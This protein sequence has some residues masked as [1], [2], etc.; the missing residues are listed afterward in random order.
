V[1]AAS[2]TICQASLKDLDALVP[3]FDA[4]RQF[5]EQPSDLNVARRFLTD[6]LE[7]GESIIFMAI[8]DGQAIGFTQLYPS[9][10]STRACPIYI[11]NDLFVTPNGRGSGAGGAL[12]DTAKAF[13]RQAGAAR[14]TLSTAHSNAA[15]QALYEGNGWIHDADFR[16][17]NFAL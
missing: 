3:L 9:F 14:L 15:A 11:L 1:A 16:T 13:G 4:Y 6:R 8:R 17:Y 12:L 2:L 5:Y 10:S 7:G